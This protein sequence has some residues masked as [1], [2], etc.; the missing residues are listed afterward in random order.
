MVVGAKQR[1]G[2]PAH[3]PPRTQLV[4][5]GTGTPNDDPDRSG[6]AVA[7]V[8]GNE[9]YL[10]DAGPGIVRRAALAKHR[11]SLP[12]LAAENLRR[13]FIT[14]LHSDHTVGLPDLIFSPWVLGRTTPLE[15]YG[16]RGTRRMSELLESAYSED[17]AIRLNGG[18]PSNKTGYAVAAHDVA[19]GIVYRDSNVTVT[20]FAVPHGKW[21]QAFGYRFE[22]RDR[23]IVISG[24][25]GPSDAVVRACNGCDVLVHE[26]YSASRLK[27]RKLELATLPPCLP[28]VGRRAGQHR[29]AGSAQAARAL[30]P[31]VLGRHGRGHRARGASTL[32][33]AGRVRAGPRP[34]LIADRT[35]PEPY[36]RPDGRGM[37]EWFVGA[38]PPRGRP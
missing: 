21:E 16:P 5:L 26:V 27:T 9:V 12:A 8:V 36:H 11:D 2:G 29:R 34:L 1:P 32:H 19:P 33:R 30:S 25:T 20:A 10:V 22:T 3:P 14:H 4:L 31:A 23:S 18:E 38:H 6:P 24:D 17:I 13:V 37:F 28:H 15:I 35:L 7:I